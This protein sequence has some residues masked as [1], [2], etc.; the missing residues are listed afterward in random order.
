MGMKRPTYETDS[1]ITREKR[2]ADTFATFSGLSLCK[3]PKFYP[4][5]FAGVAP[6]KKIKLWA[7]VKTR[8]YSK[9]SLDRM[10]GYMFAL[11]RAME[12]ERLVEFTGIPFFLVLGL[13]DG[14]FYKKMFHEAHR[15]PLDIKFGG[16]TDRGDSDDMEPMLLFPLSDFSKIEQE[17]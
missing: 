16:R 2:V 13:P 5:D 17:I 6:D 1:D 7:E 4:M 8:T 10:G 14:V 12:Y 9:E 15:R 3:L 11:K